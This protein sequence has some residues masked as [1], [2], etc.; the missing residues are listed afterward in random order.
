MTQKAQ[1]KNKKFFCE[2]C[3]IS[4]HSA[5]LFLFCSCTTFLIPTPINS[6]AAAQ[7]QPCSKPLDGALNLRVFRR[8]KVWLWCIRI[9]AIGM[10]R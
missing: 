4:V 8:C 2:F 7:P 9:R 1:K 3:V 5:F 6:K 10:R